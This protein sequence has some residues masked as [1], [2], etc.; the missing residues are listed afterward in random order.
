M[1]TRHGFFVEHRPILQKNIGRN[2]VVL[3]GGM[4]IVKSDLARRKRR[5]YH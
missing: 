1:M 5:T 3:K 2:N 4:A